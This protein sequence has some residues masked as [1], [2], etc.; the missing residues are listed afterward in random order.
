MVADPGQVEE[1]QP[2]DLLQVG[3]LRVGQRVQVRVGVRVELRAGEVVVP[4]RPRLDLHRL[5][6]D[7]RD[8]AG[9]RLVV[10]LGGVEQLLVA[11]GPRLVVVVDR[12][13]ARVREQVDER[14]A[15]ALQP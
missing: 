13:H 4:V 10:S 15:L 6:G 9:G 14:P 8:R 3:P 12:R 7:Q 2:L 1:H 11:V 5:A